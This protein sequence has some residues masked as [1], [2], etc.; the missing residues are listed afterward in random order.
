MPFSKSDFYFDEQFY[1][2]GINDLDEVENNMGYDGI[3]FTH[4]R[5]REWLMQVLHKDV[6]QYKIQ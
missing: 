5:Y 3:C 2:S 1:G 6:K 4:D